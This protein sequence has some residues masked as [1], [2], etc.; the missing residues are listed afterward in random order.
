MIT[1]HIVHSIRAAAIAEAKLKSDELLLNILPAAIAE[2]LKQRGR[3]IPRHHDAVTILFA[4]FKGFTR[5]AEVMEP[6]ALIQL[7]DEYFTGFDELAVAFGMEKLKAIGDSYMCVGGLP[8]TNRTHPIDACLMGLAM[9]A[10][11]EQMK[12]QRDKFRLPSLELRVGVHTG[13]VMSGIV[14]KHKFTYDVWGDAVNIA[15]RL[16]TNGTPG[17]V[18]ISE[19]THHHVKALFATQARG[20]V[21]TKDKGQLAMFFVDRIRPEFSADAEGRVPDERFQTLRSG[22]AAASMQWP[23]TPAA[24]S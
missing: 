7:L 11:V 20:V 21:E 3:V 2:E 12:R 19:S 14:G 17:R 24:T 18:N 22:V 9:Q 8:E 1:A 6:A 10:L 15:S 23:T 16:E 13:P 5:L 4:D